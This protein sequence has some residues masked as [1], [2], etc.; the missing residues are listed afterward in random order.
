MI[1]SYIAKDSDDIAYITNSNL[2]KLM[3]D[4][5]YVDPEKYKD[6]YK[7]ELFFILSFKELHVLY[8]LREFYKG[9]YNEIESKY[10]KSLN[11][12]YDSKPPAFHK[13]GQCKYLWAEYTNYA[14]PEEIKSRGLEQIMKY[15]NFF[16]EHARILSE[17]P[18]VFEIMINNEF[19]TENKINILKI[20]HLNSGHG[21][22]NGISL[23]G[24]EDKI[25]KLLQSAIEFKDSSDEVWSIIDRR[26]YGPIKSNETPDPDNPLHIWHHEFKSNLKRLLERYFKEKFDPDMEISRTFLASAGFRPCSHCCKY[27]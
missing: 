19:K 26:G 22:L 27:I 24:L 13:D 4:I 20:S 8:T 7:S 16:V 21:E 1:L 12:V 6:L 15:K 14:I 9:N 5:G 25:D 11:Y 2:K 23:S 18:D 17:K 3:P 10:R